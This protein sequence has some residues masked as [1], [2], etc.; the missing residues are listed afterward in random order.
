MEH[1]FS[2]FMEDEKATVRFGQAL[3][4]LSRRGDFYALYGTLGVGKS[5]LSRAFVQKLCGPV[6]V[7]SPTFTLVQ[8]YEAPEFEIYHFDLYRIKSPD[9]IFEIGLEE[10]MYG[11]VCLVEWPERMKPYLPR[12]CFRLEISP[13]GEGRRVDIWVASED[14]AA[15]L[16]N[17]EGF[18]H[19]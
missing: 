10:A 6:E 13:E 19:D 14:K 1:K 9:E 17:L 15:R 16:Q 8:S 3:A 11:G 18:S 2:Y 4:E 12:D 5:V 7:P